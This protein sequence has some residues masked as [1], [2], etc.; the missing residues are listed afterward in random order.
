LPA[1]VGKALSTIA[2][3]S[4]MRYVRTWVGTERGENGKTKVTFVWEPITAQP[5]VRRESA[6]SVSLIAASP[7]GETYF[8][9]EM[10]AAA[11]DTSVLRQTVFEAPP[12]RLQ[13]RV[14]VNG[15]SGNIDSDDREVIVPDLTTADLKITTPRVYVARTV[16]DFQV[17]RKDPTVVPT[18]SREFRRTDR[19]VVRFNAYAPGD[20]AVKLTAKLLNRQGAK[21]ADVPVTSASGEPS[22][23][24]L[25]LAA[26]APSEYLLEVLASTEGHEPI[27][28]LIAFRVEG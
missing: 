3:P 22:L 20:S 12:G 15:S 11:T 14:A 16:R 1:G 27:K 6:T 23:I 28:E 18:V 17:I 8:R 25:P 9:G 13:L 10:P 2:E 26:L 24:D 19:L 4:R 5:G 7:D 21:L